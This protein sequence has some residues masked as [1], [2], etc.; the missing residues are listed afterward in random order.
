MVSGSTKRS[1]VEK[2]QA[3]RKKQKKSSS[4]HDH[5]GALNSKLVSLEQLRWNSVA[6]PERLED[7]E[8]FFGLEEIDDVEVVRDGEQGKVQYR[9]GKGYYYFENSIPR[10]NFQMSS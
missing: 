5:D 10:A 9:V 4:S 8:G 6:L 1:R 7:A 2:S 3:T